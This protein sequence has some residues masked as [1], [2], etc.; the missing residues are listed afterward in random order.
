MIILPFLHFFCFLACTFLAVFVLYKDPKSLLNRTCAILMLCFAL[1]NFGDIIIHNPDS[2]ITKSTVVIMQNIASI[3]WIAF[4]SALLCFSL[5][6]S[7]KEKLLKKKWFLFFVFILPLFFV[8]KQWTNCLTINPVRQSY[9]WSYSW[10]DT[11]LTYLFYVYYFLFT[12]LSIF[13]IYF[14]GRKTK[15]INEKKQAKVITYSVIAG[16]IIGTIFDVVIPELGIINI[17]TLGNLFVFIFAVGLFYAIVKYR[18]LTIT[19]AIAAE[20]II[21]AIDELLILLNQEGNILIVNKATTDTLQYGQSELVGKS[22][23]MLFQEDNFR[24]ELSEKITKGEVIKNYDS[25]FLAKNGKKVPIIYSS[26]QLKNEEGSILG[27][28]II[29]R[30]ISERKQAEEVL[31]ESKAKYQAIFE[32]TGTATVI[33]EED[34]TI[35]MANNEC[36]PTMGYTPT[37]LIGQ[38][39]SQ[40]AA[41]E[42]LQEMLKNQQLRRQNPDLAPKKYEVKLVNKK[43]EKRDVILNVGMISGTKQRI[44]SVLDITERKQAEEDLI[45]A[46][47]KAEE[48][49]RLKTAFLQNISHEIRTPLNAILGFSELLQDTTSSQEDLKYYLEQINYGK[50]DLLDLI[51]DVMF[52][53][54]IITKQFSST[55]KEF[56]LNDFLNELVS[57]SK[58][59][60]LRND[61]SNIDFLTHIEPTKDITIEADENNIKMALRHIISNAIKYTDSGEIKIGTKLIDNSEVEFYIKDTGTGI[62]KSEFEKIFDKFYKVE[63]NPTSY[64]VAPELD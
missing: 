36:Y 13:F 30:D 7:K 37:E 15:I 61:K 59:L 2:T 53:S 25:D 3:G 54:K 35:L 22:V 60:I 63:A 28:A 5:V 1:W 34:T 62:D 21:S 58:K 4:A 32:S 24:A 52:V 31:R 39:W 19:P 6:F 41:P 40:Y 48:S 23:T 42:S 64:F 51:E 14:Y 55:K 18:F 56:N 12:L 9:G 38:K 20:N 17:P 46:K 50:D 27:T 11:I 44:V 57:D 45:K 10:T 43:G 29:A 26:F 16:L 47:E 33:I 49:D 8:Y